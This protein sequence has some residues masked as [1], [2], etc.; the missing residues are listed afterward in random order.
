M[1]SDGQTEGQRDRRTGRLADKR[2][3]VQLGSLLFLLLVTTTL[4]HIPHMQTTLDGMQAP[5]GHTHTRAESE[6]ERERGRVR[7]RRRATGKY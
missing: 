6:R 4:T 2:S 3:L 5:L 1:A 7:E